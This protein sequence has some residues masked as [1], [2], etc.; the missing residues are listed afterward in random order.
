MWADSQILKELLTRLMM[1]MMM[2]SIMITLIT[3]YDNGNY[4]DDYDAITTSESVQCVN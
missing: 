4:E 1:M 3:D 2:M